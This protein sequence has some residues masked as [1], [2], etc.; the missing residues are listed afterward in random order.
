MKREPNLKRFERRSKI[1]VKSENLQTEKVT[2]RTKKEERVT[3]G[4]LT[5][6]KTLQNWL[7]LQGSMDGNF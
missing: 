5:R 3:G 1:V 2:G 4:E 6:Y 7:C